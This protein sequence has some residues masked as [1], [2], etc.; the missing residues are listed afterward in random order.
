MRV[1]VIGAGMA[2][3]TAAVQLQLAGHQVTVLD[4]GRGIGGRMAT[5]RIGTATLDHGAQFFT[6]RTDEFAG[7]IDP[8]R[9]DGVVFEWSRG[10]ETDD[11]H[12]RY[13]VRGGMAALVKQLAAPLDVRTS[14][15][16]FTIRNEAQQW[17][18]VD[19]EAATYPCDAVVITCPVPQSMALLIDTHVELPTE[20]WQ[21]E[22]DRTLCLLAVLSGPSSIS[23]PGGL[24]K[25]DGF[26]FV[27]DNHAKGISATPAITMHADPLWSEAH[28]DDPHDDTLAALVDAAA[29]LLG[30]ASVIERQLKRWRFATPRTIWPDPCWVGS[31][32]H[33]PVVLAGD[34]FAGPR[35]EGAARSGLAAASALLS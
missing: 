31:G 17:V 26:T 12:P 21:T 1:V 5:R 19:D 10:F 18:V 20:L 29:P 24:Q 15:R 22:Y 16:A 34:A 13:A 28:W 7:L 35:V 9:R 8:Y 27:A 23:A 33:P 4:K 2:G 25:M 32:A 3:V 30:S 11:G 14:T 6:V